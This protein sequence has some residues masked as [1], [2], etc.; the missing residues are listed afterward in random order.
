MSESSAAERRTLERVRRAVERPGDG[1]DDVVEMVMMGYDI[2]VAGGS[3]A[4][5]LE[6]SDL[7]GSVPTRSSGG[8]EE[9][10]FISCEAAGTRFEFEIDGSTVIGTIDPPQA[11]RIVLQQPEPG[12]AST[13]GRSGSFEVSLASERPF[14]LVF[15]PEHGEHIATEWIL[16]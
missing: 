4:A 12:G 16:P 14:R 13:I 10:R 11:G 3:I 6:D 2:T 9:P 15:E 8:G 5:I 7:T 1:S